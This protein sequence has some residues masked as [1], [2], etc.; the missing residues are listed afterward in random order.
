MEIITLLDSISVKCSTQ[1]TQT[2]QSLYDCRAEVYV[3]SWAGC[4]NEALRC[5]TKH[6]QVHGNIKYLLLGL[7]LGVEPASPGQP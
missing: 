1:R 5:D 4:F 7:G 2:S 3:D 6:E